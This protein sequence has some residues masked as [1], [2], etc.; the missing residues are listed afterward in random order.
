MLTA[1]GLSIIVFAVALIAHNRLYSNDLRRAK[2]LGEQ[3]RSRLDAEAAME[4]RAGTAVR[5]PS[6]HA[7]EAFEAALRQPP[8]RAAGSLDALLL[9]DEAE[10]SRFA[11]LRW[12]GSA[13][14]APAASGLAPPQEVTADYE[15]GAVSVRWSVAQATREVATA[16]LADAG[17]RV[18]HRLYRSDDGSPMRLVANLDHDETRWRD[19]DMPLAGGELAYEVWTVLLQDVA[20]SEPTLV[21]SESGELVTVHVPEHFRLVLVSGDSEAAVIRMEVGPDS[22]PVAVHELSLSVGDPVD[23]NGLSTG[24]LLTSLEVIEEERLT[25]R[26]RLVLTSDASLVL[27]PETH[28]PRTSD[29]QVLMPQ[30]RLVATLTAP[31]GETR[32]LELDLQ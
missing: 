1:S 19:D 13:S 5:P 18:G 29:T 22:M 30:T 23:A 32:R 16:P 2:G 26:T 3:V 24:L 15:A 20:G 14:E 25:T 6:M 12:P 8:E 27:D 28:T 11:A 17:Q 4:A 21:R 31:S 9:Y 10:R 7:S